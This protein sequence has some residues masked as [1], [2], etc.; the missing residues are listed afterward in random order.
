MCF[1]CTVCCGVWESIIGYDFQ[2]Y[3]PW[4]KFVPG[5]VTGDEPDAKETGATIIS[6]MIFL[7]YVIALNTVVPISLYVR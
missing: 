6:V 3:M 2:A 7:S 5:S 4:E 1:I